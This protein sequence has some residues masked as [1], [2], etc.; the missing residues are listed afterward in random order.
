[1]KADK[2]SVLIAMSGGV[3]SSVAAYLLHEQGFD[4][5]GATM[6]LFNIKTDSEKYEKTCCDLNDVQDAR[7]VAYQLDIPFYVFNF[8]DDFEKHVITRFIDAYQQGMTPN[9]CVDCNRYVKFDRFLRRCIEFDLDFIATGHY[10]RICHDSISKRYLLQK[11]IDTEKD[12]SYVLYAMTQQQ[13]AKT[14][15][16]LGH[17][18]KQ[19]VR[20]IAQQHGLIN[21]AKKESQDI[22]FVPDGD[23]ATFIERHTGRVPPSGDFIDRDRARFGTPSRFDSIYHWSTKGNRNRPITPLLCLLTGIDFQHGCSR[24]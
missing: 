3:D 17:Y 5:R 1:M 14:F 12:Q 10:A 20:E 11:A 23:Y 16:P 6:K 4:C 18:R 19:E 24:K 21:A 13:L 8:T 22:C 2:P 7:N 9:P 15:F